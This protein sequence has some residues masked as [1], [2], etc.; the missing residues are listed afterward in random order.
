MEHPKQIVQFDDDA[1]NIFAPRTPLA[2]IMQGNENMIYFSD[3][4][5]LNHD[6][7]KKAQAEYKRISKEMKSKK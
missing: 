4:Q 1:T 3:G 2:T 7:V 5:H 6:Q